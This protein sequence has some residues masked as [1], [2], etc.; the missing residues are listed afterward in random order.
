MTNQTQIVLN[1]R[2]NALQK[3]LPLS[4]FAL[5]KSNGL[6]VVTNID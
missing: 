6:N 5:V 3:L 1:S 4:L 2:M